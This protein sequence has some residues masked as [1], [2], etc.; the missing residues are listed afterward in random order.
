MIAM[1]NMASKV[2]VYFPEIYTKSGALKK[3][4]PKKYICD[5]GHE[6]SKTVAV[7]LPGITFGL[8]TCE[9][10]GRKGKDNPAYNVWKRMVNK[11][12]EQEDFILNT[13][14]E[15]GIITREDLENLLN[16]SFKEH[17]D[18]L[19]TLV[20]FGYLNV[21]DDKRDHL[22]IVEYHINPKKSLDKRF[23][24]IR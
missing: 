20:Y 3:R 24:L 21:N 2:Y 17:T 15:R 14:K 23:E 12:I 16:Q 1:I 8:K 5:C 9:K 22:G 7:R 18:A 4:E 11:Q 6:F 10:C 13:V 19:G